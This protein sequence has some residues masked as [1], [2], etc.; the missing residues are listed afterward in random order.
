ML[1]IVVKK[2]PLKFISSNSENT[3][4]HQHNILPTISYNQSL[5]NVHIC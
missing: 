4:V 3:S 1:K 2:V 5:K